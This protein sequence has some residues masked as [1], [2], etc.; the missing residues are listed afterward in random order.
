LARFQTWEWLDSLL[1]QVLGAAMIG[2]IEEYF[3]ATCARW[4]R[5]ALLVDCAYVAIRLLT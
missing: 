2:K 5:V 1:Q 3:G 4:F